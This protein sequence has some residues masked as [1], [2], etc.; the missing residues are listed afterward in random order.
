M[1]QHVPELDV[2]ES[3]LASSEV[4]VILGPCNRLALALSGVLVLKCRRCFAFRN[5]IG[6]TLQYEKKKRPFPVYD[7]TGQNS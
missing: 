7:H 3:N 6:K 1:F 5:G 4:F 2:S